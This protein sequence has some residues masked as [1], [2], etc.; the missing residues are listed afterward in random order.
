MRGAFAIALCGLM[1]LGGKA[2]AAPIPENPPAVAAALTV[3][4]QRLEEQQATR[5][6]AD[7]LEHRIAALKRLRARNSLGAEAELDRLLKDSVA[8]EEALRHADRAVETAARAV[9]DATLA[10]ITAIDLEIKSASPKLRAGDE[11][12]RKAAAR[13]IE[14]LMSGRNALRAT[15]SRMR[16]PR[17]EHKEW[18]R[19]DVQIAPLD[20]PSELSEKA[21]LLE[22]TRDRLARKREAIA[23]LVRERKQEQEVA[24]AARDFQ[25]DAQLF[26]E[27]ARLGRVTR[28]AERSSGAASVVLSDKEATPG[29]A[30]PISPTSDGFTGQSPPPTGVGRTDVDQQPSVVTPPVPAAVQAGPLPKTVDPNLLLNLEVG[31]LDGGK[32]DLATLERLL[33][34]LQRLDQHLVGRAGEIRR[35]AAELKADEQRALEQK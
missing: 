4:T 28:Q 29:A 12:E 26:D 14:G 24:R 22:D 10:A 6:K 32:A 30:P 23:E 13:R 16:E 31:S 18:A 27:N 7:A 35:R 20:G 1:L 11:R 3:W 8:A 33:Q 9:Q 2:L 17:A 34:D 5:S 15:L 19:Y 21:D 25:K